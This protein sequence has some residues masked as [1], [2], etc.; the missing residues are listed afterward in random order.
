MAPRDRSA[1]F[2]K[3]MAHFFTE[4]SKSPAGYSHALDTP[5]MSQCV[6]TSQL[7]HEDSTQNTFLMQNNRLYL[8]Q[9][10]NLMLVVHM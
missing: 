6:F 9:G 2:F 3:V 4:A 1:V 8:K 5:F 7:D 10:N